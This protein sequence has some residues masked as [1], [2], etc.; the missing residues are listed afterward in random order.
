M[1]PNSNEHG[2]LCSQITEG[3]NE[4]PEDGAEHVVE[5]S[6]TMVDPGYSAMLHSDFPQYNRIALDLIQRVGEH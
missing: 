3:V 1:P 6:V 4:I 2:A 5:F